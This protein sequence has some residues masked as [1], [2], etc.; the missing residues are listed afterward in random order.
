MRAA[1][2]LG[3]PFNQ[4][5]RLHIDGGANRS[6]KND[7]TQ[8]LQFKN[9]KP[10]Y[11]STAGG[12]SDLACTGI[13][14][15]PWCSTNGYTILI[16]CYY[17]AQAVDTIVS[18]SDIALNHL[19]P[20]HT[21]TQHANLESNEG[22]II[23][24]NEHTGEKAIYPLVPINGLWYYINDD[25]KDLVTNLDKT[26]HPIINRI[27]SPAQYELIHARLGH[28]GEKTMQCIHKHVDGIPK[29]HKPALYKC[30]TCTYV[31]ITKR[32][33][34]RKSVEANINS[35]TENE[36]A[37]ESIEPTGTPRNDCTNLQQL[38]SS[39]HVKQYVS[40]QAFHMDMGF[41]RGTKFSK[42]DEDG[43]LVTSIDGYNSYLLIVDRATRYTWVFLS[44]TKHPQVQSI[45]DFLKLH[46]TAEKVLKTIRTDEGGEL[47]GSHA[48]QQAVTEAGYIMEPTA[49][50]A[51]FQNGIAERPNRTFGDMMRSLLHGAGLGPEYWSWALVH[52][53]YLKNRIPQRSLHTTP[54]EAYTGKRPNLKHVRVFG[55]PIIARQPGRRPAKLDSHSSIGIFLGFTATPH[56]VYYMDTTTKKIKI[57]THIIFDEAG[58][59]IPPAERTIFQQRLQLQEKPATVLESDL[60]NGTTLQDITPTRNHVLDPKQDTQSSEASDPIAGNQLVTDLLRIHKLTE[61]AILPTRATAESAGYDL[62]SAVTIDVPP[63]TTVQIPT[64]LSLCPPPGHL[65]PNNV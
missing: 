51:S 15:L 27:S 37:H 47:W 1:T 6:I 39:T 59:T 16:R 49:S 10:Y 13:G 46:G 14:Y 42:K 17:S 44:K 31:N 53:L 41:V 64:D 23:F 33:V 65:L 56:N 11:M 18:P 5:L 62:Y 21:W 35:E 60:L 32:A 22:H 9:I 28:P 45:V 3:A 50:D 55:S 38:K 57:G 30:A 63:N 12:E 54:Y 2:V 43:N 40:G 20:F 26:S 52:A 58:Y 29:L 34:T 36:P 24:A 61:N 8:L 19:T 4:K 7:Y 48:F 25:H